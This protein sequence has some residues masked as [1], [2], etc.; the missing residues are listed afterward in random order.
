MTVVCIISA[1]SFSACSS[2]SRAEAPPNTPSSTAPTRPKGGS[3]AVGACPRVA[4]NN[5]SARSNRGVSRLDETLVPIDPVAARVCSYSST[6]E[7]AAE[8]IVRG[9]AAQLVKEQANNLPHVRT[10]GPARLCAAGQEWFIR[11]ANRNSRVGVLTTQTSP[12][13]CSTAY[14]GTLFSVAT[15]GWFKTLS[16]IASA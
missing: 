10:S 2:S 7:L 3:V 8:G 15:A 13:D 12:A 1:L 5:F 14:N 16:R 9:P 6:N 11:F 4:P